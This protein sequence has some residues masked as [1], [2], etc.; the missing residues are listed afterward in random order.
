LPAHTLKPGGVYT[1]Q[2]EAIVGEEK[3]VSL[4]ARFWVLDK[5]STFVVRRMERRFSHSALTLATLY[6]TYGLWDKAIAQVH[7]LQK[8]NP[9][10]PAIKLL[11]ESISKQLQK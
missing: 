10:H 9:D 11:R 5:Q 2:V 3:V 1:W 4:P 7:R 8:Q 6:A